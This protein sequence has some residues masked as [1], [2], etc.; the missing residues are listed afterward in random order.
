MPQKS[1]AGFDKAVHV[2]MSSIASEFYF[3]K[4][5]EVS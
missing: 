4:K 2:V 5:E 1:R 3:G